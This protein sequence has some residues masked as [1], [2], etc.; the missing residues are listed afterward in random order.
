MT[1]EQY[2][3]G[4]P[5]APA[6]RPPGGRSAGF[7][8]GGRVILPE[9]V[10]VDEK[11]GDFHA[12]AEVARRWEAKYRQIQR[13]EQRAE[14]TGPDGALDLLIVAYG[15][16][17]RVAECALPG[18]NAGGRTAG[19]LR[20]VTLWPFPVSGLREAAARARQ[21]TV[22]E[23]S[24][25]QLHADVGSALGGRPVGLVNWLGGYAPTPGEFARSITGSPAQPLAASPR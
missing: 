19:I 20:P 16:L 9:L 4:E 1:S 7:G 8:S 11:A 24:M 14:Y 25:G 18:L 2:E 13:E 5:R 15:S 12:L 23:L 10:A 6:R 21:V 17:A 3:T 22:A